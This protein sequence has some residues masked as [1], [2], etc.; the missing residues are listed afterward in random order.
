M[1]TRTIR[2]IDR[3]D[4][5]VTVPGSKSYTA[6]ALVIGALA[7]GETI[8][9]N[10]LFS[11]D[12]DCMIQG[13][14]SLG[15][16]IRKEGEALRVAGTNG[17]L[18]PSQPVLR[19]KGAGTAVRFLT[20][21]SG[22]SPVPIL[23]DGNERMRRRPIQDLLDALGPLGIRGRSL[24]RTG[25]PP[26]LIEAGRFE[27]G[28]TLLRGEKSSQFL[29]SILLASPYARKDVMIEIAGELVSRSYV[30]LTLDIM[31][32]FGADV[33]HEGYRLF[34]VAPRPYQGR[35]YLIEGDLSSA[36]YFFAAAAVSGGRVL[37]KGIN[38]R[39]KQG[40]ETLLSIL[41]SMGCRVKR[42][43]QEIE[44]IGGRLRGI[45]ADMKALPDS[46]QTLAVVAAFAEGTTR[47]LHVDHLQYKE[48]DRIAALRRELSKMGIETTEAENGFAVKGGAP[49]A[50]RIETYQ[51]HRMAMAF[52]V[53]G[54]KVPG[55]VIEDPG[56]V[57]K[58]F[59]AFWD[60]M[61][62][63]G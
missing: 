50:A 20:A 28:R 40:D 9:R 47:I 49:R 22:L 33:S 17:K 41:E 45:D 39:T 16:T 29:S 1:E 4:A 63:L 58:S 61:E 52:A 27:G 43:R 42:G 37:V 3:L 23:I 24:N 25:C 59:P 18:S 19:L 2:P 54:L 30:D 38:P 44:L 57:D 8:L 5:E 31:K 51:D 34:H 56:C 35:E 12:T 32:E 36:S 11:E 53:A 6:R 15:V 48:T 14:R 62:G 46:V 13:L 21:L 26:V 10:P 60:L 55:M 7:S